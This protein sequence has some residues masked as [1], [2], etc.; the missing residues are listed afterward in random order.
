MRISHQK[1][2]IVTDF[3]VDKDDGGNNILYTDF[4]RLVFL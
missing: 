4:V 3:H 1:H 2:R